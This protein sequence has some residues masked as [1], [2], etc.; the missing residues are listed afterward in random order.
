MQKEV[1]LRVKM[2]QLKLEGLKWRNVFQQDV[3]KVKVLKP[4]ET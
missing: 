2:E 4:D 3:E 1:N